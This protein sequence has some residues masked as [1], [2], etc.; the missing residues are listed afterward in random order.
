VVLASRAHWECSVGRVFRPVVSRI[1]RPVTFHQLTSVTLIHATVRVAQSNRTVH[2]W[3]ARLVRAAALVQRVRLLRWPESIS[4]S[5]ARMVHTPLTHKA[6]HSV[7]N[8]LHVPLVN[9][10]FMEQQPPYV[11]TAPPE[12]C[13]LRPG[14]V[15]IVLLVPLVHGL[16]SALLLASNVHQD[17]I[18]LALLHVHL[19]L[20]DTTVHPM[21]ES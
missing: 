7:V 21:E 16:R 4:A 9:T 13:R 15:E 6:L 18:H 10:R 3:I 20:L 19:V 17:N 8:V 1:T 5:S 11:E 2:A 12:R 14:R